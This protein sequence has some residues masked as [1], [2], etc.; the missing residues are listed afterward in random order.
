MTQLR[1]YLLNAQ[2]FSSTANADPQHR[3]AIGYATNSALTAATWGGLPVDATSILTKLT[4]FGD[5]N[6][7]GV[8]SADDFALID[9]GFALNSST[10]TFGDFNYDGTVTSADYLL[11]DRVFTQQSGSFSPDAALLAQRE[12]QFGPDYVT[13]LLTSIP[14]PSTPLLAFAGISLTSRF[15]NRRRRG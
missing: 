15:R 9:R 6:L 2:L 3:L 4:Y 8:I 7:D 13:N 14:E 1:Q 12:S 5:A 10:W 11:I